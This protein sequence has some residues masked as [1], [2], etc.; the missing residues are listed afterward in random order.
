MASLQG[1]LYL[2]TG[3]KSVVVFINIFLRNYFFQD[4]AVCVSVLEGMGF[5]VGQGLIER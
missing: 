3:S 4:R 1:A 5:R 2:D